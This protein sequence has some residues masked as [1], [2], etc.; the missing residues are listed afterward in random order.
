MY[1][2]FLVTNGTR[3]EHNCIIIFQLLNNSFSLFVRCCFSAFRR[4][5]R[6]CTQQRVT[7]NCLFLSNSAIR[8]NLSMLRALTAGRILTF[9]LTHSPEEALLVGDYSTVSRCA[10][11]LVAPLA[12]GVPTPPLL[13]LAD[14]Q[15]RARCNRSGLRRGG[16]RCGPT[17][18]SVGGAGGKGRKELAGS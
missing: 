15:R 10:V 8:E 3:T 5:A 1:S 11:C 7:D 14:T 4:D 18:I 2:I 13:P 6:T 16:E 12:W 17:N 9:L